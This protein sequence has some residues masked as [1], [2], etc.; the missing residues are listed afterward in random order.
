MPAI[1]SRPFWLPPLGRTRAVW[2]IAAAIGLAVLDFAI[3]RRVPVSAVYSVPVALAAW[4]SG[5]R[6]G[7]LIATLLPASHL[8]WIWDTTAGHDQEI[9]FAV[10]RAC[11]FTLLALFI[12]RFAEHERAL[13][14]NL[15][16]LQGLLP[17]CSLCKKIRNTANE[18]EPLETYLE[19]RSGA[20]F[21]HSICPACA[22]E[23]YRVG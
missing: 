15:T 8:A 20:E 13:E 9:V 17:L 16:R 21:S 18:W 5:R 11:A 4:Y 7:L 2:W 22:R 10:V 19:S 1:Y 23:R 12:F 3:G 14:R 6:T